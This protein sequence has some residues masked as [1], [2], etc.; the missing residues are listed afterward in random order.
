MFSVKV[1]VVHGVLELHLGGTLTENQ[2]SDFAQEL[3][4]VFASMPDPPAGI[5]FD[6]KT[7]RPVNQHV[8]TLLSKVFG[9]VKDSSARRI[10]DIGNANLTNVV[11]DDRSRRFDS[12]DDA[13]RW[14]FQPSAP[15]KTAE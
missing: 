15:P 10:A 6:R 12:E 11:Y 3:K 7:T 2:L 9:M 4:S 13:R 1:D 14:L 8:A 5:L